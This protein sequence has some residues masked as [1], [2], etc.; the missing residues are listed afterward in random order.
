M[1]AGLFLLLVLFAATALALT[2]P[3]RTVG[4]EDRVAG[5][6]KATLILLGI[7]LISAPPMLLAFF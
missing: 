7:A 1:P 3:Q 4:A 5:L 6:F 2:F